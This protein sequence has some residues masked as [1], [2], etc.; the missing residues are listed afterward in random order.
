MPKLPNYEKAII[1][2]TKIKHYILSPTHPVGRFKAAFFKKMGYTQDNWRQL[3]EDIK[4]YH[5]TKEAE[6]IERIKY[7]Q[8]YMIKGN[9]KGPN[10]KIVLLRSIWIILENEDVPRIS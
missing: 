3:L 9:I 4:R 6:P 5:L 2:S 10:G 8:K 1:D 7:G